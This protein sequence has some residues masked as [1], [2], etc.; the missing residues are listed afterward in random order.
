MDGD[1]VLAQ[2]SRRGDN[3]RDHQVCVLKSFGTADLAAGCCAGD[4]G[5]PGRFSG[6]S[7]RC[8]GRGKK[9]PIRISIRE[10][11]RRTD[12]RSEVIFT[13]DGADSKDLDDAISLHKYDGFL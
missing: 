6:I 3:H 9:Y 7:G 10:M 13:I 8:A 2:I 5:G 1:K 11:D 4:F 12:L